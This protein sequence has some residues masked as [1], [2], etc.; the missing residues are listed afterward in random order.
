[1]LCLHELQSTQ[2]L[3]RDRNNRYGLGEIGAYRSGRLKIIENSWV[4][5]QGR[6]SRP[7]TIT[8]R[9]HHM[10]TVVTICFYEMQPARDAHIEQ[11]R[12]VGKSLYEHSSSAARDV[13]INSEY[14]FYETPG[15]DKARKRD[16][17]T[18][19]SKTEFKCEV[20]FSLENPRIVCC[21]EKF[22]VSYRVS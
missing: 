20:K 18:A 16:V 22:R 17:K 3:L 11:T 10:L 9:S 8:R 12:L 2:L 19:V 5:I 6:K 7:S 4:K 1:M 14:R 13:M 21:G 15:R